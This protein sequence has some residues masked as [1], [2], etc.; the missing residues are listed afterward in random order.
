MAER[1]QKILAAAGLMSR[2][3][4]EEAILSG[5][6]SVNGRTAALGERAEA[7][8]V[9]ALDGFTLIEPEKKRYLML[10]KPRGYVTTL[11]DE[12]GRKTVVELL[13]GVNARVYPV[14]RLDLN[15]EG[16]LLLTND[17]D[18]ANRV[19]H[20]S[21]DVSKTYLV[22]IRGADLPHAAERLSRPITLDG[23][24]LR[25]ARVRSIKLNQDDALLSV[26]IFE[27]RNRQIR[28]MCESCELR[29]TRLV[30]VSEGKL[31]LGELPLGQWRELTDEEIH[32]FD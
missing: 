15:S 32:Y 28:R 11:R 13:N 21:G 19:M 26:T 3:A 2:R 29:V 9:I 6:V 7:D 20:P 16:L 17:G 5:R 14:G 10:H 23:V 18:F 22:W 27:G 8:D 12:K 4:A 25:P 1:I 30:R 31:Q 24:K